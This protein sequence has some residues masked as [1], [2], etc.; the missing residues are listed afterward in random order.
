MQT[1]L[2]SNNFRFCARVLDDITLKKQIGDGIKTIKVILGKIPM[3][4]RF[5][6]ATNTKYPHL[7]LWK[8]EYGDWMLNSL[9]EYVE[10]MINEF[11]KRNKEVV[12]SLDS[13]NQLRRNV[14]SICFKTTFPQWDVEVLDS[15]KVYLLLKDFEFYRRRIHMGKRFRKHFDYC[16]INAVNKIIYKNCKSKFENEKDFEEAKNI[17]KEEYGEVK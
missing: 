17:L 9:F 14:E 15:M 6:I 11:Q 4:K 5:G 12:H 8:D 1:Y 7:K 3:H 16:D 2:V 10:C 13:L